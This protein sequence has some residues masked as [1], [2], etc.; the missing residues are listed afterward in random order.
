MSDEARMRGMH[1]GFSDLVSLV[2]RHEEL[3]AALHLSHHERSWLRT[4][5]IDAHIFL[6]TYMQHMQNSE[7]E[8][9]QVCRPVCPV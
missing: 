5:V 8:S 9:L 2:M 3:M 4:S 6:L 1:R 7:A